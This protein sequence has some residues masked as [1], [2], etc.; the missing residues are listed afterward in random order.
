MKTT[1]KFLLAIVFTLFLNSC[2]KGNE[3]EPV[4]KDNYLTVTSPTDDKIVFDSNEGEITISFKSSAEWN[5]AAINTRADEWCSIFPNKGE[6]GEHNVTLKVKTN[7]STDER[8][9]TIKLNSG[10][11]EELLY[12]TQKQKDALIINSSSYSLPATG[13]TI[14]IDIQSNISYSYQIDDKSE[15]WIHHLSTKALESSTLSFSIDENN[16]LTNREGTIIITGGEYSEKITVYQESA[17]PSIIVSEQ[18]IAV[19]AKGETI[20]IEVKGNV[21]ATPRIPNN[22]DWI[23]EVTT[24]AWSTNT[25]YFLISPNDSYDDRTA[26]I[27][28]VNDENGLSESVTITQMQKNA[29]VIATNS[30]SFNNNGGTFNIEVNSN[31]DYEVNIG[32]DWVK[33]V[34]T[35]ALTTQ[36]LLFE[37]AKNES[38]D[39]RETIIS[40]ISKD[41]DITQEVR[42]YQSQTNAIIISEKEKTISPDGESFEVEIKANISYDVIM[43]DVDWIRKIET[44]ALASSTLHLC[45]E[46][47]E[48]YDNRDCVIIIRDN[49]NQIED[50]LSII[51]LQ[52]DAIV[53]AK[54]E[55]EFTSEGGTLQIDV[56]HN[57]EYDILTSS[58]WIVRADTKALNTTSHNFII[59]ANSTY[60]SREGKITF[61][62]ERI[63]QEILI[64]QSATLL[65]ETTAEN[66]YL[67]KGEGGEFTFDVKSSLPVDVAISETADEWITAIS[68]K[69][70]SNNSYSFRVSPYDGIDERNG[71]ISISSGDTTVVIT[72]RQGDNLQM[73]NEIWYTSIDGN[74]VEPFNEAWGDV[75]V[76]SNEY[77]S[78]KNI[79]VIKFS[80]NLTTIGDEA[81][82]SCSNL[83]EIS[84]PSRLTS[85][86][87]KAFQYCTKLERVHITNITNIG[88]HVFANCKKLKEVIIEGPI[89]SI[90]KYCF[91][92]CSSLSIIQIPDSIETLERDAFGNCTN[93]SE[94]HI[95]AS[96]YKIESGTFSGSGLTYL[97]IPDTVTSLGISMLSNCA[98][99]TNVDIQANISSIP[100]SFCQNCPVL[101]II[102]LP[103][104]ITSIGGWAFYNCT[105]LEDIIIPNSVKTIK[106]H[107]FDGCRG[108][109]N[110]YIPNSVEN[111]ELN[112]FGK[113]SGHLFIDTDTDNYYS[114]AD[115]PFYQATFTSAEFG[116]NVTKI[117]NSLLEYYGATH[118]TLK[119]ITLSDSIKEIGIKSF[120]QAGIENIILS[121][122]LESIGYE[123]FGNNPLLTIDLPSTLKSI[124]E[125]AFANCDNLTTIEIPNS[126][127]SFGHNAFYHC[128]SLKKVNFP[129][130]EIF[131]NVGTQ[132]S[133]CSAL[134]EIVI[135]N[136]IKNIEGVY[137]SDRIRGAF[138][139]CSSLTTIHFPNSIKSIGTYSFM[140][141]ESLHEITLPSSVEQIGGSIFEG[142]TGLTKFDITNCPMITSIPASMFKNCTGLSEILLSEHI[143]S[144]KGSAFY[145]CNSLKNIE[146]SKSVEE[147]GDY[148][149][150]NCN[151][152]ENITLNNKVQTIGNYAFAYCTNLSNIHCP[153][154]LKKI[155]NKAFYNCYHLTEIY[156]KAIT[157][158]SLDRMA[159]WYDWQYVP[160]DAPSTC[161]I[162]VP[163]E[164]LTDYKASWSWQK[165]Q[166]V[167]R[168]Y[169]LEGFNY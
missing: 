77:D 39:N 27:V 125:M 73:P 51:Q 97:T 38:Y 138:E 32:S 128:S 59:C 49:N 145:G 121:K 82:Y 143:T 167:K 7:T 22:I 144:I 136:N 131:T 66:E 166:T 105:S 3:Q 5:I 103:E 89:K 65:F 126:V 29:I 137:V 45:V 48:T 92:E 31:V 152:L 114:P 74:I 161:I 34:E 67:F 4:V 149:F 112:C 85:I 12:V 75:T 86:G 19:G 52:K 30:Y 57:I 50:R 70:I 6:A 37:V 28:F 163:Q 10:N 36:N 158:P 129:E 63:S 153:I 135:P 72:I 96:T 119:T 146:L 99:L 107:A 124:G 1:L 142:C 104:S 101:S 21:S 91:Y 69:V 156:C 130:N 155:G 18:N 90:N 87:N 118:N 120:K 42:V 111:L 159:F 110:V 46:A 56:A 58:D 11:N 83:Y 122:N 162:Y 150:Y 116:N 20:T 64:K 13:G 154:S 115:S 134:E 102:I 95:P 168:T 71:K 79:G 160:A 100:G 24:K 17:I 132:Y 88:E 14:D 9:A 109:K 157:P 43:P 80:G 26:A 2:N 148:S 98:N 40:F 113:C 60:D 141:C 41:K 33:K 76:V 44:K 15:S 16:E 78:T 164:S 23:S 54:N 117:G 68:T 35:K 165:P 106:E 94:F 61:K 8:N 151:N 25:Y 93:L 84:T 127:E 140:N 47:N 55:Y 123:A 62:S 53:V 81:F 147:L 139:G 133:Y 169:T 108:S